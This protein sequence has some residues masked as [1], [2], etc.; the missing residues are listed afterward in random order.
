MISKALGVFFSM[1]LGV[2]LGMI[3]GCGPALGSILLVALSVL[4]GWLLAD[5]A[6]QT[7]NVLVG[8]L[9]TILAL[10]IAGC[11]YLT[12]TVTHAFVVDLL[13]AGSAL[14]SFVAAQR[15]RVW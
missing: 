9:A 15:Q 4:I 1:A 12:L 8:L 7:S 13:F 5:V 14:L 2:L 11:L 3:C 6:I 10:L